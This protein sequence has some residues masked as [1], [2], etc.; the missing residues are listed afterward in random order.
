MQAGLPVAEPFATCGASAPA[1]LA[2]DPELF[3]HFERTIIPDEAVFQTILCGESDLVVSQDNRRYEKWNGSEPSHPEILR[4]T[5]VDSL[6]RSGNDFA[7]KFQQRVDSSALDEI[8]RR[9]AGDSRIESGR[10][11]VKCRSRLSKLSDARKFGPEAVIYLG[12]CALVRGTPH[13]ACGAVASA[14]RTG[15][16]LVSRAGDVHWYP[17]GDVISTEQRQ[18]VS[19]DAL[20]ASAPLAGRTARGLPGSLPRGLAAR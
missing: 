16:W 12:S 7:R 3:S 10:A 2:D 6:M 20:E 4:C 14:L 5:D 1:R 13:V 18:D 17:D 9:R 8:D 19:A 15:R 11:L